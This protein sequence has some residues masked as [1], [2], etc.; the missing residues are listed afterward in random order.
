MIRAEHY[1]HHLWGKAT[2]LELEKKKKK[3]PLFAN[4]STQLEKQHKNYLIVENICHF[5]T[6]LL[7]I[8]CR[9]VI[10]KFIKL[11]LDANLPFEKP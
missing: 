3:K 8:W 2:G 9:L 1:Y 4:L 7:N 6:N 10:R 5:E 11:N